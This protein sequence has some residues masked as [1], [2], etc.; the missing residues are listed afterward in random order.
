M[1]LIKSTASSMGDKT[2]LRERG[3]GHVVQTESIEA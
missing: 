2:R 3:S 1:A